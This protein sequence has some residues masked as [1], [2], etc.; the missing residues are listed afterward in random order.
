[1]A[2]ALSY[3]ARTNVMASDIDPEAVQV[4][5]E[6]A[7]DCHQSN[8]IQF[9][10][11]KGLSHRALKGAAPYDV[12]VANILA[13]PL[14]QMATDISRAVRP[15]GWLVLSGLLTTQERMVTRTYRNRGLVFRRRIVIGEWSTLMLENRA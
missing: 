11:A 2:L 5:K 15:G 10:H 8:R 1:M 9:V 13:R 12:I 6:N 4:A 7:A 14:C 3:V